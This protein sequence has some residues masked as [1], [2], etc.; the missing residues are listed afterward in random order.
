M[1]E[2]FFVDRAAPVLHEVSPFAGVAALDLLCKRNYRPIELSNVLY[3]SIEQ[4]TAEDP[5]AL[6]C[7]SSARA[8]LNSGPT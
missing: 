8:K 3:R 4:P 2:R 5:I 1:V 6:V 7:A